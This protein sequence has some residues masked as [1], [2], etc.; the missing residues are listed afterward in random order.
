[1]KSIYIFLSIATIVLSG[2]A[3]GT[4]QSSTLDWNENS[5]IPAADGKSIQPGLAGALIGVSNDCLII[6]GG[7]NFPDGLPWK[8]GI[9]IYHN[10]VYAAKKDTNDEF[11]WIQSSDTLSKPFGYS[12]NVAYQNGFISVGG[13]NSDGPL[14]SVSYWT[15]DIQKNK[16][17]KN[18]YPALPH[19]ITNTSAAILNNKLFVIGG[20]NQMEAFSDVWYLDLDDQEKGWQQG[21]QLPRPTSHSVAVISS[22]S[23]ASHLYVIGGRSKQENGISQ[24][25]NQVLELDVE[26]SLWIEKPKIGDGDSTLSALSAATAITQGDYIYVMGGDNGEIFHKIESFAKQAKETQSETQ[27]EDFL[28][29]QYKL[30]EQHPGFSKDVF[31][32]NTVTNKWIKINQMPYAPVTTTALI[33]GNDIIIPTGEIHPGIRTPKILRAKLPK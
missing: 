23:T 14:A 26:N 21:P 7:A 11:T 30:A 27:R 18:E 28:S 24:L 33:W 16:I 15:W 22:N 25:Y 5:E 8:G 19:A 10:I 3:S 12:A 4:S 1:M 17:L 9:K 31:Q 29:K 13:E 2:C 32:Y 20:E 6:A